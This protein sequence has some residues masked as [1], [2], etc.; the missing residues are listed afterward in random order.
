[1]SVIV[2]SC[3]DTMPAGPESHA[4]SALAWLL[5]DGPRAQRLLALTGLAP[6]DLRS[7]LGDRAVLAAILAFL[8]GHE[9][10]LL[11]CADALGTT[12]AALVAARRALAGEPS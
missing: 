12:P 2:M 9:P 6:D 11:A 8:E 5:A 7:G 10:D 3:S 1:M 4:L